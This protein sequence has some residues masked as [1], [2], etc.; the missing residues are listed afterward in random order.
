[1]KLRGER[2]K[3]HEGSVQGVSETDGLSL[4]YC[5]FLCPLGRLSPQTPVR[6]PRA[7][8]LGQAALLE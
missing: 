7:A 1:M 3:G 8:A 2:C 4:R 5:G 6:E